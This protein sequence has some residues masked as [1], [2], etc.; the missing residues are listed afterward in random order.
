[1]RGRSLLRSL[2]KP[3]IETPFLSH[4][5]CD[6]LHRQL[7]ALAVG[8]GETSATITSEWVGATTWARNRAYVTQDIRRTVISV[9]RT[10]RGAQGRAATMRLD[11]D[12]LRTVVQAAEAALLFEPERVEVL[13]PPLIDEPM[14]QPK[15]WSDATYHLSAEARGTLVRQMIEPAEAKAMLSFGELKVT[16]SG[17]ASID[18]LGHSRYYPT[19]SVECSVTVRDAA[20]TGSG[21]A[22][23]NDFDVTRIDTAAL[24]SRALDKCL[25]SRTPNLVE[26]GHYTAVLEAQAVADL[27][28]PLMTQLSRLAAESGRGPFADSPGRSKIGQRVID[29]RF[30]LRA[31]PMD[32]DG[33]F[34]PFDPWT[35][36]PYRDVAWID[37]GVLRDLA[38]ERSY[39]LRAL[40]LDR[41]LLNSESFR[42]VSDGAST[43][44]QEM[45]AATT[46]GLLVTRLDAVELVDERSML[47]TGYTRDGVWLIERGTISK[48]V[49]NFRFTESSLGAL[50]RVE[51]TG[52]PI[53]VFRPGYSCVV[54]PLKVRDFNFARLSDAV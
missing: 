22:G 18:S 23:M 52:T 14:T 3:L 6:A 26:P 10:I 21:W 44:V 41:S 33:A 5:E 24:A 17:T 45:V 35:G 54:P 39:A 9:A 46:R 4:A 20:G 32:P 13:D 40:G 12:G 43:S 47:C 51:Q 7:V 50:N 25:S 30:S 42:L 27:C 38:Y 31:N 29:P 34:F 53:R 11:P 48:P 37:H 28:V 15:L 19:T 49:K 1:M 8:G 36:T 16:A 2:P